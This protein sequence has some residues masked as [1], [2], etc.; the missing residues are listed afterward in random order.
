MLQDFYIFRIRTRIFPLC[1]NTFSCLRGSVSECRTKFNFWD[2]D[3]RSWGLTTV[4]ASRFESLFA[5]HL[6]GHNENPK[7]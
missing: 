3:I 5:D 4:A 6:L 7:K 2:R 1:K